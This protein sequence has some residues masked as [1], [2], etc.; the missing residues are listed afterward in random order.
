MDS[1]WTNF[2]EFLLWNIHLKKR[3]LFSIN[4]KQ[5]MSGGQFGLKK[6]FKKWS[7]KCKYMA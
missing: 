1:L 6:K 7:E 5:F 2:T 3:K 4:R